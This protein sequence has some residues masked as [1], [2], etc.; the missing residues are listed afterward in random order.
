[1]GA[2]DPDKAEAAH[3]HAPAIRSARHRLH[4]ALD[5]GTRR[6]GLSPLN[7]GI[8]VVIVLSVVSTVLQTE[9]TLDAGHEWL[10]EGLEMAFASVFALE[11][12]LRLWTI[13]EDPHFRQPL[14]GRLRWAVGPLAIIDLVAW[15][16]SLF[17]HLIA[18]LYVVSGIAPLY[19]LRILRL[20]RILRLAKLGRMSRAWTLIAE[21]VADRRF[22]LMVTATIGVFMMLLSATLLYMVEGRAQPIQFGSIPRALWWSAMTLTTIGYGDVYPSTVLGKFL[23]VLTAVGGIG[24]IA[25]PT[26]IL[27]SA[28]SEAFQ[29]HRRVREGGDDNAAAGEHD[30]D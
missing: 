23:A 5:P 3:G 13:V 24:L 11:Y 12:V 7:I 19:I 9:P 25:A 20:S 27:A 17:V 21:A 14:W 29:K 26:G 6:K 4:L 30:H 15:A 16:P 2:A 10:F 28:F 18:P 8:L 22:E 1:M